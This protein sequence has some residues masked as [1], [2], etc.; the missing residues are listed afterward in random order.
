M[1]VWYRFARLALIVCTTLS[2][3]STPLLIQF[4]PIR[5]IAINMISMMFLIISRPVVVNRL[6]V[7]GLYEKNF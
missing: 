3:Y 4:K 7:I 2:I 5:L 1:G 6:S